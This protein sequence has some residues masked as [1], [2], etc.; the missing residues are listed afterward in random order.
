MF[1]FIVL[2]AIGAVA[3]GALHQR[4]RF[5]L[6]A[7]SPVV[8]NVGYI[9][10]ALVLAG[11][12]AKWVPLESEAWLAD[13]RLLGLTVG[14]LLGGVGQAGL[15]L[16]GIWR[17]LLKGRWTKP[18]IN[19]WNEHTK[20]I[21]VLM[22]P[23]MI[24]ASA[25]QINMVINTNFA[26]TLEQGA[27]SWLTFSFRILQLPIGLFGV[28]VGAAVLPAL[29]RSIAATGDFRHPNVG[30][31]L[32]NA[33]DLVL[34]L[35]VPCFVFIV[36]ADGDIVNLLFRHGAFDAYAAEQTAAALYYYA[37]GLFGYGLIKVLTSYYYARGRTK[38]AMYVSLSSIGINFALNYWLVSV[39]GH[40]GIAFTASLVLTTNAVLLGLGLLSDR[41]A[42][43]W[44][45]LF[46]SL[47]LLGLAGGISLGILSIT[48]PIVQPF[49][50][51]WGLGAKLESGFLICLKGLCIAMVFL[52]IGLKR[53]QMHPR[54]AIGRLRRR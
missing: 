52:I 22:L 7:W 4:G 53:L 9:L 28:A 54:E 31:E 23:M 42:I 13:R 40:K 43:S 3:M 37:F 35:M 24:A 18:S 21:F 14:V 32:Q 17:P 26:T 39:F 48:L 27:V 34:W 5:F 10:G 30:R 12:F 8:L 33:I 36:M 2:M 25:G 38:F 44:A 19:L 47:M 11:A 20:Q 41:L 50:S 49:V 6:T 1:P 46:K 51:Q 15:Q 29:S 45:K 16:W